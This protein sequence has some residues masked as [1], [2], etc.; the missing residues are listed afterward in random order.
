MV[1]LNPHSGLLA[2]LARLVSGENSASDLLALLIELDDRP[3]VEFFH[4]P[5]DGSYRAQREVSAGSKGRP[6]LVIYGDSVDP[7]IILEMKAGT[8]VHS[9]QLERYATWSEQ[10]ITAPGLYLCTF[11]PADRASDSTWQSIRLHDIFSAWKQSK[12]THAAWLASEIARVLASWDEESD[13]LVGELT[14]SYVPAIL[15][16][17]L[18]HE[19]S[20]RLQTNV[21][22][23]G[24]SEVF[25]SSGG[26]WL[27]LSRMNHPKWPDDDS[28]KVGVDLRLEPGAWRF[29]P[30]VQVAQTEQ[31]DETQARITAHKLAWELKECLGADFIRE[32]LASAGHLKVAQAL[33]TS[34]RYPGGYKKDPA[35]FNFAEWEQQAS[36]GPRVAR[37]EV[38]F[39][40]LQ[41]RR[42]AT[43]LYLDVAEL[44]R[45]EIADAIVCVLSTLQQKLLSTSPAQ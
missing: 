34:A 39:S 16:R 11:D 9:N 37:S 22:E 4:L 31:R 2:S 30:Y 8:D 40:D 14:G 38:F 35:K 13:G 26:T 6:D 5:K 21:H 24:A 36:N 41:G 3:L 28:I 27:V 19:V 15:A 45:F 12:H 44:T 10:F 20:H 33:T 32:T 43:I 23:T 29:R 42:A 1:F 17:R 25:A 18:A 7:V